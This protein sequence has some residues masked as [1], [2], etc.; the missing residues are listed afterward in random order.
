[1]AN[2]CRA[3]ASAACELGMA[4]APQ[5]DA[6]SQNCAAEKNVAA[7]RRREVVMEFILRLRIITR[8]PPGASL[9][10]FRQSPDLNFELASGAR[11]VPTRSLSAAFGRCGLGTIRA[12]RQAGDLRRPKPWERRRPGESGQKSNLTL[13][14]GGRMLMT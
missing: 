9:W 10:D 3:A 12:P 5:T 14:A 2:V 4:K 6:A 8:A 1:M 7:S 11:V 13:P